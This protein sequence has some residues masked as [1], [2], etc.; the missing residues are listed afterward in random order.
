MH[1]FRPP[2]QA[3]K[4]VV[5]KAGCAGGERSRRGKAAVVGYRLRWPVA[6]QLATLLHEPITVDPAA[7]TDA[8]KAQREQ[9]RLKIEGKWP[10]A[11]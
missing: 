6:A 9:L 11:E 8:Q 7:E 5:P 4:N 3:L 10:T 2:A 1:G